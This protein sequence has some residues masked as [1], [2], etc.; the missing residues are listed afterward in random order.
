[1]H[2][3][4]RSSTALNAMCNC[5]WLPREVKTWLSQARSGWHGVRG[6]FEGWEAVRA[7]G[8]V[9][10][11]EAVGRR[12]RDFNSSMENE[13]FRSANLARI[14][15]D[16]TLN[17]PREGLQSR[18]Q[19]LR[20]SERW[21]EAYPI[22]DVLIRGPSWSVIWCRELRWQG[23]WPLQAWKMR[24]RHEKGP[25]GSKESMSGRFPCVLKVFVVCRRRLEG[26]CLYGLIFALYSMARKEL[27]Q[28]PELWWEASLVLER[29]YSLLGKEL[30]Y[31][32]IAS[33]GR[34]Q[35]VFLAVFGRQVGP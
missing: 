31:D 29:A 21:A 30:E 33:S 6:D 25:K 12:A 4:Q 10:S 2:V 34:F 19:L 7:G 17:Q 18:I 35:A 32:F 13:G 15:A 11:Q 28:D 27:A 23:G 24:K 14:H 20:W 5:F 9:E 16:S 3:V 22:F 1:M 26:F 8:V